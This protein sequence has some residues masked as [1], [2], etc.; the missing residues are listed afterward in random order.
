MGKQ[1]ASDTLRLRQY[2]SVAWSDGIEKMAGMLRS[3]DE[4]ADQTAGER[5]QHMIKTSRLVKTKQEMAN[6]PIQVPGLL[7]QCRKRESCMHRMCRGRLSCIVHT[8]GSCAFGGVILASLGH[9]MRSEVPAECCL[10]EVNP[11]VSTYL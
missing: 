8:H 3:A 10:G 5:A 1:L 4:I 9:S 2:L 6:R 7:L 11:L